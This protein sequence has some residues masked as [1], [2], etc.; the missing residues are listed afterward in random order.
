MLSIFFSVDLN[1]STPYLGCHATRMNPIV[2]I[3]W[4]LLLLYDTGTA[5]IYYITWFR[6]AEH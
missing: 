2:F 1:P 6:F 4:V 3:S 5:V